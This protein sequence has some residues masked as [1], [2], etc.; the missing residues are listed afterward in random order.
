MLGVTY[1]RLTQ[2]VTKTLVIPSQSRRQVL[3]R[4]LRQ[5]SLTFIN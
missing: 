2:I 1:P 4:D 5:T 3:H